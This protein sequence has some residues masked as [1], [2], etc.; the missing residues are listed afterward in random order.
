M[1]NTR[2]PAYPLVTVDPYLNIWSNTDKLTDDFTYHWTDTRHSIFGC[3]ICD[4]KAYRF[5]GKIQSDATKRLEPDCLPQVSVSVYPTQTVYAFENDI[6]K[7]NLTFIT[8]LLPESLVSMSYPFSYI[9]Y[10]ISAKDEKEH[11]IE[12]MFGIGC[13]AAAHSV[14]QEVFASKYENGAM[15]GRGDKDILSRSGDNLRIDWGYLHF[16]SKSFTPKILSQ[17]SVCAKFLCLLDYPEETKESFIIKDS[18]N[19]LCLTKSFT[20]KSTDCDFVVIAYD[21]IHSIEYFKKPI[22]SYYKTEFKSFD[23][24]QEFALSN[25]LH[26]SE[27][28][29][30]FDNELIAE[31]S[32]ISEDYAKILSVAYRQTVAAHKLTFDGDEIQYFSKECFSNGCIGTVD[33]TYPSIPLFLKYNPDLVEGMLNPI[34]KYLDNG[35]CFDFAPHDVGQ[36]PLANGQVY[37]LNRETGEI[38]FE[39]QMPVEECGNMIITIAALCR[40]RNDY[41]Y[42]IKHKDVLAQW[43]GYLIKYGLDPENQLCTDDFSGHLAHNCNLSVKAIVGIAC[44]GDMLNRIGENGDEY[45]KTAREYATAWKENAFDGD[46]YRLAFDQKDTWS[47]K[48]N[49]VW[50]KLLRLDIFDKDIFETEVSYYLTKINEYGLPLDSRDTFTKSDWQIWSCILS[51]NKEYREKIISAMLNF[52][53]ATYHRVPFTDWYYTNVPEQSRAKQEEFEARVIGFQNR[54]VQGGLFICLLNNIF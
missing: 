48:Y 19:S 50:D 24:V 4:N 5:M 49:L 11:E 36:Y 25:F 52:L 51:D 28:C 21:D 23:E 17:N 35:W 30:K 34:F 53:K 9:S 14:E 20:L 7:L 46:H 15:C 44:F 37:G 3:L 45:F 12:I 47:I 22:D 26:L 41:S 39:S 2:Y 54:T 10:E 40:A 32:A 8:P 42:F 27:K 33:V 18:F 31:A 29:E 13:E 16:F 38:R 6:L 43:A 1:K